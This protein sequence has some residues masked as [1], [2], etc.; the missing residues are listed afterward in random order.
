MNLILLRIMIQKKHLFLSVLLV[1]ILNLCT[2]NGIS[3][4]DKDI[5]PVQKYD[6]LTLYRGNSNE[7][8]LDTVVYLKVPADFTLKNKVEILIDSLWDR[9]FNKAP[10]ELISIDSTARGLIATIN[11]DECTPEARDSLNCSGRWV[12]CYFE[13]SSGGWSTQI[14]LTFTLLQ[15]DYMGDWIDGIL[16]LYK[17]QPI[18]NQD[19]FTLYDIT[20]RDQ[21]KNIH[22]G[23]D[24]E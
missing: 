3:S 7:Y 4:D 5:Q 21:L 18:R 23:W 17:S 6:T 2:T 11:L 13:G 12:G 1:L 9:M 16:V 24:K 20:L 22:W 8:T 10:I 15:P 14:T 19:H